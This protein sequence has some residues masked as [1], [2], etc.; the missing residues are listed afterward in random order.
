MEWTK[1]TAVTLALECGS[2]TEFRKKYPSGAMAA[3]KKGWIDEIYKLL[4]HPKSWS[5]AK[6]IEFAKY[7]RR[8]I[9]LPSAV[10]T[11]LI[12]RGLEEH[13]PDG[14]KRWTDE[15]L[16]AEAA[17]YKTRSAFQYGNVNAYHAARS[18]GIL[19]EICKHMEDARRT[20]WSK[21]ST[22]ED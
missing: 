19:D 11:E 8:D 12:N 5:N 4:N 16:A 6:L 2:V 22:D 9:D 15:D 7:T 1:E 21:Q 14:R 3:Y 18:H 20:R 17:R 10:R 13:R